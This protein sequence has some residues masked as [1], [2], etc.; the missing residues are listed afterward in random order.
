MPSN[1]WI[2]LE[3]LA[4]QFADVVVRSKNMRMGC[5]DVYGSMHFFMR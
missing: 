2:E 4:V 3:E 5:M 1:P